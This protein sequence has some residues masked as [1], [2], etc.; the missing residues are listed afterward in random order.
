MAKRKIKTLLKKIDGA[1]ITTDPLLATN[2]INKGGNIIR[3]GVS[4]SVNT[5]FSMS[6]NADTGTPEFEVFNNGDDLIAGV[7]YVFESV[8]TGDDVINFKSSILPVAFRKIIVENFI[9]R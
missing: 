8:A 7:D 1:P 2:I 6:L 3:I 9:E 5:Q 4:V